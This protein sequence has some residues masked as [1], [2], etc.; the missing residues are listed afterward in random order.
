LY[1]DLEKTNTVCPILSPARFYPGR[2][3]FWRVLIP[4]KNGA[5]IPTPIDDRVHIYKEPEMV[6]ATLKFSGWMT[7]KNYWKKYDELMGCLKRDGVVVKRKS[8]PFFSVYNIPWALPFL[9][10]NEVNVTIRYRSK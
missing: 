10:R 2:E 6:V 7:E 5:D 4:I 3:N 1:A 9:R 8:V